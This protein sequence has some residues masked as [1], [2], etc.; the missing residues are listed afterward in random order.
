[1]GT[2]LIACRYYEWWDYLDEHIIGFHMEDWTQTIINTVNAWWV[3][4]RITLA[5]AT[6]TPANSD[7]P[8]YACRRNFISISDASIK[9][10]ISPHVLLN[11]VAPWSI[12]TTSPDVASI[13]RIL[14]GAK[15]RQLTNFVSVVNINNNPVGNWNVNAYGADASNVNSGDSE[16]SGNQYT[17]VTFAT[18]EPIDWRI[19]M[20]RSSGVLYYQGEYKM[21]LRCQ[22][23]GGD[24]GDCVVGI[25]TSVHSIGTE[26]FPT[27]TSGY[28]NLRAKDAG[29][30][31]VDLGIIQIPFAPIPGAMDSGAGGNL[32]FEIQA[33]RKGGSAAA[34]R[35]YDII[36]IPIDE[37]TVEYIDPLT[38]LIFGSS[39]LRRFK[40]IID[41]GGV[42]ANNTWRCVSTSGEYTQ[43]R[44]AD[45]W[46][47]GGKPP[48]LDPI[49]GQTRLFFLLMHHDQAGWGQPPFFAVR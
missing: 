19:R 17:N 12:R 7:F 39:A 24:V 26:L 28:K 1:M 29:P 4:F 34:L 46:I 40:S 41:D 15:S 23:I 16:G 14:V 43:W 36:L 35:L 33:S 30:E 13:N 49:R 3:R 5:G 25:R 22:Q 37:W 48:T 21:F 38:D 42:V 6:T 2:K 32:Y 31:I 8:P 45:T 44:I 11:I 9:G 20:R 47:R 27:V 10:D 18:V